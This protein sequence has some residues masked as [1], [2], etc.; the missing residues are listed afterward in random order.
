MKNDSIPLIYVNGEE[1]HELGHLHSNRH[2]TLPA[3]PTW[4]FATF[5]NTAHLLSKVSAA[6]T[7]CSWPSGVSQIDQ[8]E[9]FGKRNFLVKDSTGH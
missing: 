7:L 4:P 6:K 5:M 1:I 8:I 3:A 9:P 2:F